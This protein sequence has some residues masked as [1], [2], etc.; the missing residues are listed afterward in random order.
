MYNERDLIVIMNCF[1]NYYVWEGSIL[2]FINK[3]KVVEKGEIIEI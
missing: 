1:L 2:I 3:Q